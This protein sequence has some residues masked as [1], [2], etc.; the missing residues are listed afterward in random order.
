MRQS[1]N[2]YGALDEG[3]VESVLKLMDDNPNITQDKIVELISA[4]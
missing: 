3:L 4:P 2:A 1:A